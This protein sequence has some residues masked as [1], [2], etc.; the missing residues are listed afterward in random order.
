MDRGM[1]IEDVAGV[2]SRISWGAI[3]GGSMVALAVGL[4]LA[5]F[6]AGVGLSLTQA[7]VRAGT[8]TWVAV[9]ANV[10]SMVIALFVGGWVTTQLTAGESRREAWI[11][12]VLTWGVVMGVAV[13]LVTQGI[14][15]GYNALLGAA[16]VSQNADNP[17]WE[18]AARQAG[19]SQQ[20]IDNW[21]QGLNSGRLQAEAQ[22]PE[23][24]AAARRTAM[25]VSWSTLLA[26]LVSIAAAVLGSM[27]GMGPTFRLFPTTIVTEEEVRTTTPITS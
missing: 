5:L 24:V 11:H 12:G 25:I 18:N 8:A 16:L 19:V 14:Q 17:G 13:F 26:T 6:F 4:V 7:G 20:T 3:I 21:K 22:N 1:R 23:N 2:R 10:I 27:V 9:V 15:G